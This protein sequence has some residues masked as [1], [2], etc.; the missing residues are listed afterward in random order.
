MSFKQL[1]LDIVY[2]KKRSHPTKNSLIIDK[3]SI[4][5]LIAK[6]GYDEGLTIDT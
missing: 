4:M 5:I 6:L 3:S 1:T 2:L